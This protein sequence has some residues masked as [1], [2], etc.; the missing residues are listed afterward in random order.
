MKLYVI[1]DGLP[2]PD[3]C[4][5]IELEDERG[6]GHGPDVGVEWESF[7]PWS[8]ARLG[9]FV[10]AAAVEEIRDELR[11]AFNDAEDLDHLEQLAAGV[12][13]RLDEVLS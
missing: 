1:C 7:G 3:S 2:G 10:P 11:S 12:L 9:P 4:K 13:G 5:F 8:R 6:A